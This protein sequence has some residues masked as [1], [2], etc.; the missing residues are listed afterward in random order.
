MYAARLFGVFRFF[1]PSYKV[2]CDRAIRIALTTG[3]GC[4]FRGRFRGDFT[5]EGFSMEQFAANF[6]ALPIP[7]RKAKLDQ[8]TMFLR[9]QNAPAEADAFQALRC[10][11][12]SLPLSANER[13]FQEYIAWGEISRCQ[14]HPTVRH[15]LSQG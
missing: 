4:H 10:C 15:I 7:A 2:I 1:G 3:V 5:Y 6:K 14:D 9:Q 13:V 8:I 12:P 11:Y